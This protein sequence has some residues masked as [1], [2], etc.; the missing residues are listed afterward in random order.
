MTCGL[1]G[2]FINVI[3]C[4]Q[5]PVNVSISIQMIAV[6]HK[7]FWKKRHESAV[8]NSTYSIVQYKSR[9]R[10]RKLPSVFNATNLA[11]DSVTARGGSWEK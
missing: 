4:S 3:N 11:S 5:K 1:K 9:H 2:Q 8:K 10:A 7:Q 6:V